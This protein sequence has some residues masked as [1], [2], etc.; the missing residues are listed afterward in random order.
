MTP[1]IR[2]KS[3]RSIAKLLA[4]LERTRDEE[5]SCDDAYKILD[6]YADLVE[7]GSDASEL[8]PL[9]EKHLDLCE[10]C[11]EEFAA[12]LAALREISPNV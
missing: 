12:L 11:T 4:M 6:V 7:N 5:Y 10:S 3:E 2:R 8:L 9:V 1:I